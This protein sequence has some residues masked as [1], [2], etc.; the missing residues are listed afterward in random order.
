MVIK[1]G[2]KLNY[3]INRILDQ[4][5]VIKFIYW[6]YWP[7][8]AFYFPL[9]PYFIWLAIRSRHSCFFTATNPGI[10]AGGIGL[11]SKYRTL[12]KI[13]DPWRP[14]SL[15]VKPG[16]DVQHLAD[17]LASAQ[18]SFPLIAKPDIGFRGLLVKKIETLEVLHQYL[19]QYPI[20]FI[21]QE[22]LNFPKEVGVMYYKYPNAQA[23]W[24]S[25]LTLKEFL[26]VIGD[27]QSTLEQLILEKRRARLQLDRLVKSLGNQ[28]HRIPTKGEKVHLGVIGNHSKGTRFINGNHLI[29]DRLIATFD[30]ISQRIEGFNYGRFDIKCQ[31]LDDL[32]AGRNFK[33]LEVNGVCSEPTH[34][35]DPENITYLA[36]VNAIRKHW[37]IIQQI[38]VT[39]HR[40]G[41]PYW[42]AFRMIRALLNLRLYTKKIKGLS[43]IEA[44]V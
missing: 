30:Q 28:M 29:D 18:I 13:P 10:E 7:S 43:K 44:S 5:A 32:K 36:S 16:T 34:I 12:L 39:Q 8:Q 31:N 38:G 22:F 27:G 24:I 15:L 42:P 11:E 40:A 14:K 2:M 17:A 1:I 20:D 6:E 21:L 9:I 26:F 3:Y 23:G 41:V 37:G 35:Y 4:P 19:E 33:I 25:S